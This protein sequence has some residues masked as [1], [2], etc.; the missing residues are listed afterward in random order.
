MFGVGD[1]NPFRPGIGNPSLRPDDKPGSKHHGF[2]T[3]AGG[4]PVYNCGTHKLLGGV[5]VSGDGVDQ[6][7][8]VAKGAVTG[9]I[10]P[11]PP[12][13]LKA[14]LDRSPIGRRQP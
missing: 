11:S 5:G 3:F 10:L 13:A 6:D 8:A 14:I 4:Q 12:K 2:V 1:T 9:R 7:D